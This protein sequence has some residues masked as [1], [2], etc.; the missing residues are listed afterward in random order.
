MPKQLHIP[1]EYLNAYS[2]RLSKGDPAVLKLD[3]IRKQGTMEQEQ[4]T[5]MAIQILSAKEKPQGENVENIQESES[6]GGGEKKSNLFP[7]LNKDSDLK[8][9][10]T[11]GAKQIIENIKAPVQISIPKVIINIP[12]KVEENFIMTYA[13]RAQEPWKSSQVDTKPK[14]LLSDLPTYD[15]SNMTVEELVQSAMK[16]T[17]PYYYSNIKEE[18]WNCQRCQGVFELRCRGYDVIAEINPIVG[19]GSSILSLGYNAL[20]L[21]KNPKIQELDT[22]DPVGD[23]IKTV[24][25]A[26]NGARFSI[27]SSWEN[28]GGH[29]WNIVNIN[30]KAVFIDAQ[31]N[32]SADPDHYRHKIIRTFSSFIPKFWQSPEPIIIN[33]TLTQS[34]ETKSFFTGLIYCRIDNLEIDEDYLRYYVR[35]RKK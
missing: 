11:P 16:K 29:W 31:V 2:T 15:I 18:Q 12:D 26:P 9:F 23:L 5:Q 19:G 32:I 7:E 1:R 17:N 34:V 25:A 24:E 27:T 28:G 30:G 21:F 33:N 14:I 22:Q 35:T 10:L 3:N 4:F 20:K 6:A 8:K 13:N